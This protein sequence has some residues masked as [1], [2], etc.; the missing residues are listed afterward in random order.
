MKEGA[1]AVARELLPP[2]LL[3]ALRRRGSR[4]I[5]FSGDYDSWEA[6]RSASSGYDAPSI[7]EKVI[8]ASLKVQRGEAVYERDSVLLDRIEYSWPVLAGLMWAAA[9]NN[10]QLTVLDFG[11]SLG[12]TYRQNAKFLAGL[13]V[14]W[15]IVEQPH[16]VAAG[17]EKFEDDRLEFHDSLEDAVRAGTP[18]VVLFGGALQFIEQPYELL[19]R[20]AQVPH[21]HLILDRTPFSEMEG[22]RIC[23]QHVMPAIHP[24]SY[25]SHIFSRRGFEAWV[26]S[27]GWTL[28]E[29]FDALEGAWKTDTGLAFSFKGMLLAR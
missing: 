13:S 10:G 12:S 15:N 17:R 18:D 19:G 5:H 21:R 14:R 11:G 9:R 1:K 25:P 8:D 2:I 7:L 3:R 6:A 16:F 20:I 29:E 22:D 26:A 28:V 27:R 23:V 24:A 4:G